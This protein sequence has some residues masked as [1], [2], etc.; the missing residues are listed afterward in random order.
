M[1]VDKLV[2][3]S[4]HDKVLLSYKESGS[5]FKT[6]PALYLIGEWLFRVLKERTRKVKFVLEQAMKAQ[7]RV[8]GTVPHFLQLRRFMGVD[9]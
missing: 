6:H 7:K 9:V 3:D 2:L 1:D 8:T 4:R 5:V